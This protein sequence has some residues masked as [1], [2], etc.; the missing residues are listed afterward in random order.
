MLPIGPLMSFDIFAPTLFMVVSL[1][2]V[3]VGLMIYLRTSH[4]LQKERDEQRRITARL[5][6]EAQEAKGRSASL[7]Q[8]MQSTSL[9]CRQAVR[10]LAL[11]EIEKKL[12]LELIALLP[13][14][15]VPVDPSLPYRQVLTSYQLE[16]DRLGDLV[17]KLDLPELTRLWASGSYQ[18]L[19]EMP[20]HLLP[21]DQSVEQEGM[22]NLAA[23][24]ANLQMVET[25]KSGLEKPAVRPGWDE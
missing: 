6:V 24:A 13:K 7:K 10:Q 5:T 3:M 23:L 25:D 9:A 8:G 12:A 21:P 2:L 14:L 17:R 11:P 19:C 16:M 15:P 1:A 22:V 20:R 4:M 18:D